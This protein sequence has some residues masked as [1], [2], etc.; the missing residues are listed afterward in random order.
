MK[1]TESHEVWEVKLSGPRSL[2]DTSIWSILN[3]WSRPQW[4]QVTI[5]MNVGSEACPDWNHVN[6]CMTAIQ[7]LISMANGTI[8][9]DVL[10]ALETHVDVVDVQT[11]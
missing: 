6:L 5:Q 10:A 11:L 7:E 9:D 8:S 4:R 2:P 1:S 3:P